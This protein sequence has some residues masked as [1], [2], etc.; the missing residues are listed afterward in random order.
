[1][2]SSPRYTQ[3]GYSQLQS[4]AYIKRL[5]QTI[6]VN[7]KRQ[8]SI[9]CLRLKLSDKKKDK[10]ATNREIRKES[11]HKR[12]NSI[13]SHCKMTRHDFES[14]V[15]EEEKVNSTKYYDT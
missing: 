10:T 4:P 14:K 15:R 6:E 13:L 8:K 5:G 9:T 1:M 2:L 12:Y 3:H 7:E 11:N